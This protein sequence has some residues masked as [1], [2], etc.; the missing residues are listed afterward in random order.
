MKLVVDQLTKIL[1]REEF[2]SAISEQLISFPRSDI[3]KENNKQN[4]R[5]K[6]MAVVTDGHAAREAYVQS[7]PQIVSK[8][9]VYECLNIYYKGS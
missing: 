5:E 7:W 3:V 4:R 9:V 6:H 1:L 2:G 8:D